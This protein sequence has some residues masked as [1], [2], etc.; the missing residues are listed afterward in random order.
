MAAIGGVIAMATLVSRPALAQQ[1]R[2]DDSQRSA[3][4]TLA[5]DGLA[6]FNAGKHAEAIELFSRAEAI[7]HAPPHLLYV[8]RSYAALGKLVQAHEAY[9]KI[10][11]EEIAAG[12]PKAF[13]EAKKSAVQER[14][15]LEP[16]IPKLT[17]VVTGPSG[18]DPVTVTMDEADVPPALVGVAHP[19]DP[20]THTLRAKA[21]GWK[22]RADVVVKIAERATETATIEL[23]VDES[24]A[25]EPIKTTESY[26][27]S[28]KPATRKF[29]AAPWIAFGIGVVGLAGG[30][31]F[32]LQNR[33][34]REEAD[35]ICGDQPCPA[36]RRDEIVQLDKDA[37]AAANISLIGYGVGAAA[38]ITGVTLLIV[39]K[40]S[41]DPAV[42]GAGG[43]VRVWCG[44]TSAGMAV[45]F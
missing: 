12:A 2:M 15:A 14:A 5:N 22:S 16:R 6:A 27:A 20:G 4:R 33:S 29:G 31:F 24:A 36:S 42:A 11:R 10:T 37:D 45:K 44:G 28:D 41:S 43:N 26:P 38:V 18:T 30:T 7:I 35:G 9:V 21:K 32:L 40:P 19:V 39:G 1:P 8:A 34:K 17:I 3:A 23:V 13:V 25:A